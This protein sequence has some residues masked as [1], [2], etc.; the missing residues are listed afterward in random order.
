MPGTKRNNKEN[1]NIASREEAA[2][3]I[4]EYYRDAALGRGDKPKAK[5]QNS[6]KSRPGLKRVK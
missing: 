1:G 5:T 2:R 6:L 4:R 3:G